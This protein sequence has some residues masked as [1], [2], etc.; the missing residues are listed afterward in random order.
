MKGALLLGLAALSIGGAGAMLPAAPAKKAAPAAARDWTRTVIITPEGGYRMGNPAAR[1][2]L[3]EY[4]SLTCSHCARF[5]EEGVPELLAKY[6]RPGRVSFEFRNYVRD[7]AD[8][9][10]ALL[11]RC[12]PTP[13]YFTLTERYFRT[14]KQWA[15][16]LQGLSQAQQDQLTALSPPQRVPRFAALAGLDTIAAQ[17]GVPAARARACLS[18]ANAMTKLAQMRQVANDVHKL[19]GTP[20]FLVNG[21]KVEAGSWSELEPLLGPPGG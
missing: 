8:L 20:M 4:G 2:K 3:I 17:S 7:P 14:Q 9:A 11:S 1:V 6:V 10:G 16:R 15:G 18:D 12:A 19:D 13:A 21:K 5:A